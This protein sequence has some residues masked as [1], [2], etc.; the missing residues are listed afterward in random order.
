M[1]LSDPIYV[2]QGCFLQRPQYQETESFSLHL[3]PVGSVHWPSPEGEV[4]ICF[5]WSHLQ[6][7]S[8]VTCLPGF[9]L[10]LLGEFCSKGRF[11]IPGPPALATLLWKVCHEALKSALLTSTFEGSD[12]GRVWACFGVWSRRGLVRIKM[13]FKHTWLG[14]KVVAVAGGALWERLSWVPTCLSRPFS[15]KLLL[16]WTAPS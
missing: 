11:L 16:P 4:L 14:M 12:T 13:L 5:Q 7:R 3:L 1:S 6:G 15:L 2:S 8:W 10:H 9:Q